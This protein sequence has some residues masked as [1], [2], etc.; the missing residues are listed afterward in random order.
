M[1][2]LYEWLTDLSAVL[3]QGKSGRTGFFGSFS[4][5]VID[6]TM[7]VSLNSQLSHLDGLLDG[8]ELDHCFQF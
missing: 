7:N 1:L 3:V 6:I 5:G 4:S 2:Q 8:L